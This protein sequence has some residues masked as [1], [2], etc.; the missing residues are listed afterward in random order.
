MTNTPAVPCPDKLH[1]RGDR[2]NYDP[3][4]LYGP[5]MYQAYYKVVA[6]EYDEGY[7]WPEGAHGRT[8]LY[9]KP[10]PPSE[11]MEIGEAMS[12]R[13][14]PLYQ[15]WYGSSRDMPSAK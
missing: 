6:A 10:V 3:H 4:L 7:K 12:E 11:L 5:D 9:F 15:G 2:T 13:A 8:T 14:R 1:Y